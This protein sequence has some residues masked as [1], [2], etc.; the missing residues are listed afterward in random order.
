M[1]TYLAI[2]PKLLKLIIP[3]FTELLALGYIV[4]TATI[5]ARI[6]AAHACSLDN[7]MVMQKEKGE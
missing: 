5:D 1:D 3:I 7:G 4:L 6:K 2:W